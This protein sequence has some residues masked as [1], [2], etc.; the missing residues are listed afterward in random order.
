MARIAALAVMVTLILVT[1]MVSGCQRHSKLEQ[2]VLDK[3]QD[4]VQREDRS[5]ERTAIEVASLYKDRKSIC[6]YVT[7]GDRKHIPYIIR[8]SK[9]FPDAKFATVDLVRTVPAYKGAPLESQ[10]AQSARILAS[11]REIGHKIPQY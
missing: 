3:A 2:Y 9:A 1:P 11:C 5:R 10:A 4:L 8:F 6:G 7:I